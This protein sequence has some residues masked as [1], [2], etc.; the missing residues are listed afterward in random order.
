M[1]ERLSKKDSFAQIA[2]KTRNFVPH[3]QSLAKR[4][5]P[6]KG[7]KTY[8]DPTKGITNG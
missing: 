5:Y 7:I 2:V 6:T 8:F 3:F 4:R 1:Q